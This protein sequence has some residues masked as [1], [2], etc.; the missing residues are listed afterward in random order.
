MR[1]VSSCRAYLLCTTRTRQNRLWIHNSG[2]PELRSA[3]LVFDTP[4]SKLAGAETA[5]AELQKPAETLGMQ[6]CVCHYRLRCTHAELSR[7]L[8][9]FTSY[10]KGRMKSTRYKVVHV[11]L[12]TWRACVAGRSDSV[13][14]QDCSV[15]S[16]CTASM[17]SSLM[18]IKWMLNAFTLPGSGATKLS[19]IPA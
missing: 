7:R 16:C 11:V 18:S 4:V 14:L 13:R 8:M 3:P 6:F 19:L 15:S 5:V 1:T 17:I 2:A 12:H 9:Q 10:S